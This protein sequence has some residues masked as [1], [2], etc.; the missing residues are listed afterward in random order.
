MTP[1][2]D[3]TVELLNRWY[4]GDRQALDALLSENLEWMRGYVR[5]ELTPE[6]RTRFD[7]MDMV[8]DGVVRLLRYGPRFV[9][10]GR[11]QFRAL[12]VKILVTAF[13]DAVDRH[14]AEC[15]DHRRDHGLPSHES[16]LDAL[17]RTIS[18][19]EVIAERGELADWIHIA[20]ELL[21]P[22]DRE[23]LRLRRFEELP[24]EEIARE[25]RLPSADAARMRFHRALP[26]L[27]ENVKR[28]Q[29]AIHPPS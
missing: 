12:L 9:P 10:H 17:A 2:G 8:Q 25:M 13:R 11:E 1:T 14:Q 19:P 3:D 28:L 20:M 18:Q 24:F 29:R 15:R 4:G 7:S 22:D 5:K 21:E 6:L 23:V 26:K 16:R 27:A